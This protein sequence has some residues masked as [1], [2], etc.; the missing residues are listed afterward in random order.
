[1]SSVSNNHNCTNTTS[2]ATVNRSSGCKGRNVLARSLLASTLL[3]TVAIT[4]SPALSFEP[5]TTLAVSVGTSLV[6]KG[7]N[8]L[9]GKAVDAPD[10]HFEETRQIHQELREVHRDVLANRQLQLQLHAQEGLEHTETRTTI[11]E[12]EERL[13]AY[14]ASAHEKERIVNVLSAV[15]NVINLANT[16]RKSRGN[17]L[18]LGAK[19]LFI[20]VTAL[21]EKTLALNYGEHL[22]SAMILPRIAAIQ[23]QWTALENLDVM[24]QHRAD[25]VARAGAWLAAQRSP[26]GTTDVATATLGDIIESFENYL[27][28]VDQYLG[29]LSDAC[30]PLWHGYLTIETFH[31]D[32]D[33]VEVSSVG[34]STLRFL[35][36]DDKRLVPPISALVAPTRLKWIHEVRNVPNPVRILRSTKGR[37]LA[38][39]LKN[40]HHQTFNCLDARL[41]RTQLSQRIPDVLGSTENRDWAN[42]QAVTYDDA[43]NEVGSILLT[44]EKMLSREPCSKEV[45]CLRHWEFEHLRRGIAGDLLATLYYIR[46]EINRT[47]EWLAETTTGAK[48]TFLR[49]EPRVCVFILAD[50]AEGNLQRGSE[51]WFSEGGTATDDS[52]EELQRRR[53]FQIARDFQHV[54]DAVRLAATR[55]RHAQQR[56]QREE[57]LGNMYKGL[58]ERAAQLEQLRAANDRHME[59][60]F[61]EAT[62]KA[63][64]QF[65]LSVVQD[66]I[67]QAVET[68]TEV[69][70]TALIEEGGT[71]AASEASD[72]SW[73]IAAYQFAELPEA[74]STV[75]TE[76]DS[77]H[78]GSQRMAPEL[79]QASEGSDRY[80]L[81]VV[82]P[83]VGGGDSGQTNSTEAVGILGPSY[84]LPTGLT[85]GQEMALWLPPI[86]KSLANFS[87]G[88]G[89]S[90][91][92]G[93]TQQVRRWTGLSAEVDISSR[94]YSS[95]T[96]TGSVA[97]G[98][99]FGG[100]AA[101]AVI[102]ALR[103]GKAGVVLGRMG[104]FSL[105]LRL[106]GRSAGISVL[107]H[108]AKGRDGMV[109]AFH[110]PTQWGGEGR[111]IPKLPHFHIG[112]WK[113]H[114]PWEPKWLLPVVV[115][116][117]AG[118]TVREAE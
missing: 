77:T 89:D 116:G 20:K 38:E 56:W 31:E 108:A 69:F 40:I 106:G 26:S 101:K 71:E 43:E 1:M 107:N 39:V 21:E 23:S 41:S 65:A 61:R 52:A 100:A 10:L 54:P 103:A 92:L 86:P 99:T 68:R 11:L 15:E 50:G 90:V 25:F 63:W 7:I 74:T 83:S 113:A 17:E 109:T 49:D 2:T 28:G 4:P 94:E 97:L 79:M 55:E 76:E 111:L 36:L 80:L 117:A 14:I 112:R 8:W 57:S 33:H 12:T 70:L 114:L 18:V 85:A 60:V 82:P 59:A 16:V 64:L 98:G 34:V 104:R 87:A 95:G 53:A 78:L 37:E 9:F 102:S 48:C 115:G 73:T 93:L 42:V 58:Q 67:A 62:R 5:L 110:V 88:L 29:T 72:D 118:T 105:N 22:R 47:L 44:V 81:S 84:E 27:L 30:S 35:T 75:A 51:N 19:N 6:V 3:V 96:L 46:G 66:Q 91:T 45:Y 32:K 13:K 24:T